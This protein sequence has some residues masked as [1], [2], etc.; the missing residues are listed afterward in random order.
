MML[1][2]RLRE[3]SLCDGSGGR[4]KLPVMFVMF[5]SKVVFAS[6]PIVVVCVS[7][8]LPIHSWILAHMS[9]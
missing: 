1:R 3:S 5:G 8:E 9:R 2:I 6:I 4:V 7:L